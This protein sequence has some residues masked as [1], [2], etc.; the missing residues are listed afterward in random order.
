MFN[1]FSKSFFAGR[2]P[3]VV[4]NPTQLPT[5]FVWLNADLGN[6]ANFGSNLVDGSTVTT[7]NDV[8][9]GSHPANKAG[10]AGVKPIWKANILNGFGVVR[11]DGVNDSLNINPVN[12]PAPSLQGATGFSLFVVAKSSSLTGAR[13]LTVSDT[14]GFGLFY[15]GSNWTVQT[16]GGI[17]TASTLTGDTTLFH[18][19]S[20][21]F[22][23]SAI[24]NSNRLKLR[25]DGNDISLNFGTSSVGSSTSNSATYLYIGENGTSGFWAGDIAEIILYAK[26][27][28]QDQILA[29]EVYLSNHW[30]LS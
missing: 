29:Q 4:N 5:G 3:F 10:N 22:D 11:F 23:G 16:A 25:Y 21:I 24:G 19:Y 18:H 12:S 14:S 27:L 9:A 2:R 1:S 7:W 8:Y 13:Y 26:T 28:T 15:S 20:V 6:T 30:G 17:G